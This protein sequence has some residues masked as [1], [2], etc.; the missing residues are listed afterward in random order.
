MA[1][2]LIVYATD[3]GGTKK[4]A[5]SVA[6]GVE[7]AGGTAIMKTAEEANLADVKECDALVLGSSVH[8]G[9]MHWKMKKFIDTVCS[10]FWM[11]NSIVGKVGAVF[12]CGSG[13]G[14]A[15]GGFELAALSMLSNLAELGLVIVPLPKN[16]PGY[17]VAGLQWGPYGRAHN[18]DISPIDGG[19]EPDKL[20]TSRH[21]GANITRITDI[22]T[23]KEFMYSGH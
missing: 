8:M 22:L 21:H 4:M 23:G 18:E 20:E 13:Y 15:G 10:V 14:N 12:G 11:D 5:Q 16:T 19:L 9:A 2:I 7:Y 6:D 17:P 3:Y 1:K